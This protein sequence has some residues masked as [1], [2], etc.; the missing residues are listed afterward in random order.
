[1]FG[2]TL[3]T[4]GD[5]EKMAEGVYEVL[6][7]VGV[8]CQNDEIRRALEAA[9]AVLQPDS[10]AVL[11][12]R[13]MV[14]E[15]VEAFR[16]EGSTDPG[17][18]H[19][20]F[21][22][23]GPP[24]LGTQ[25]AQFYLDPDTDERRSGNTSDF[26]TLIKFGAALD[27][28]VG[29]ALLST[30]VHPLIE[31]LEAGLLLAEWAPKPGP[32]FAWNVRQADYLV[33]MGEILGLEH[34][35]TW[36]AICWAHPL[37]FDKDC[38]DRFV[39]RVREGEATGFT[40]MPVAGVT[41]PITV[42]G[43]VVVT[44]AEHVATWIAARALNPQVPLTGSTW[45]GSIDMKTGTVSYAA[46]DAMFYSFASVEFLRR[47]CGVT[48]AASGADY[49]D[50][51]KPGL[52]AT[53]EKAHK[54]M[55]I[56]AFTGRYPG[57][58]SGMVEDGKV[59]SPIQLLLERDM[60]RGAQELARPINPTDD[61]IAMP[62]ILEVAH[63][64]QTNYLE[65]EHTLLNYRENSWLP[66]LIDRSGWKGFEHEEEI[67]DAARQKFNELLEQYEKPQGRQEQLAAM[68]EV[69]NRARGELLGQ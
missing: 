69:V 4:D 45:G 13:Q 54:A 49:C 32:P 26:V 6:E 30:D 68:R 19:R 58:G 28:Y 1:M 20:K 67:L 17:N 12:P 52:Y 33:A 55:M 18:G 59:L 46:F 44:S 57:L 34:W 63:G 42:E 37:R 8:L 43:F 66:E 35:Y 51:C 39:R 10:E 48:V 22:R 5:V 50:A 21:P 25:V 16:A 53:M 36:G 7:K 56:A 3:L 15:F 2:T 31:P 62:T 41:T 40:A 29:H 60:A 11:F 38:A 61:R 47:W 14:A 27:G 9:G 65:T 24:G 64:L 23:P